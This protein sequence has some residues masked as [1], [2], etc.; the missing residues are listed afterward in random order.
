MLYLGAG[1]DHLLCHICSRWHLLA[2]ADVCWRML[3]YAL[4]V[5]AGSGTIIYATF[6]LAGT[7]SDTEVL[8]Y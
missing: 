2:Y 4:L 3:A 7:S 1:F 8:S 6:A 5:C